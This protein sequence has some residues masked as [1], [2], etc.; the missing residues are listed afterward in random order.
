MIADRPAP[1]LIKPINESPIMAIATRDI[2]HDS[3]AAAVFSYKKRGVI[4]NRPNTS[5]SDSKVRKA[6]LIHLI[7][8]PESMV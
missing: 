6:G 4:R 8:A 3:S 2:K 1:R 5:L 7:M